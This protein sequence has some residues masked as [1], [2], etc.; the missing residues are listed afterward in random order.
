VKPLLR[1]SAQ[2][3]SRQVKDGGVLI[4]L[5]TNQIYDLNQTGYRIWQLLQEGLD[6]A[7]IRDRIQQEFDVDPKELVKELD[8]LLAHLS[9]EHLLD[10]E[11]DAAGS[12]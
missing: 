8:T 3:L 11:N 4:H 2:V 6:Y 7:A 12:A 5:E 1:P 9:S 10:G